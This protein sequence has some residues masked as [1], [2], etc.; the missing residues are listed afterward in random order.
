MHTI[1]GQSNGLELRDTACYKKRIE[2]SLKVLELRSFVSHV[3]DRN[4]P[5]RRLRR[6]SL[7]AA[8]NTHPRAFSSFCTLYWF[9]RNLYI[10]SL[11]TKHK[12][13]GGITF[14]CLC[15][16]SLQSCPTLCNPMNCNPSGSSVQE[17]LQA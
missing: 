12:R 4:A 5:V 3:S 2:A 6:R 14:M 10:M 16:K 1:S 13:Y 8:H 7:E 17:I 9:N 15:A 11:R